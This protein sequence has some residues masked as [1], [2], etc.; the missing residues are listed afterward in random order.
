[1]FRFAL[2]ASNR[3]AQQSARYYG[4]RF[5]NPVK[6]ALKSEAE[7]A[8]HPPINVPPQSLWQLPK[9]E[10]LPYASNEV[11]RVLART[12]EEAA[13]LVDSIMEAHRNSNSYY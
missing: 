13:E 9:R 7:S 11:K 4:N 1:M 12:P 8:F 5:F 10:P 2:F 6:D 3:A